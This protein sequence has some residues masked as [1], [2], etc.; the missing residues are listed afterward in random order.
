MRAKPRTPS[1]PAQP[2]MP[3]AIRLECPQQPSHPLLYAIPGTQEGFP[4]I[5]DTAEEPRK[6]NHF[7]I[8]GGH[9]RGRQ[10]VSTSRVGWSVAQEARVRTPGKEL[11]PWVE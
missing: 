7:E 11:G 1:P 4:G 9:N 8:A 10:S 6:D 5:R 2:P 3:G